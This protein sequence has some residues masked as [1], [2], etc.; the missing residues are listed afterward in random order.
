MQ[1]F[2]PCGSGLFYEGCCE[3]YHLGEKPDHALQ[4]MRSRYSAYALKLPDYIMRTTHP[5]NPFFQKDK[6]AWEK[7]ILN[8]YKDTKFLKLEILHF[9]E[10]ELTALVVFTAYLKQGEM[11]TTFTERSRFE[12]LDGSWLYLDG[13]I[14]QGA[15]C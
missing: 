7:K 2:C 5:L 15:I 9:E 11:D 1:R 8:S 12:K 10:Q 14:S 3:L 6:K 4:L 13:V